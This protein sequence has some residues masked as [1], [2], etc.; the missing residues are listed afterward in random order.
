L[1]DST[2]RHNANAHRYTPDQL[3]WVGDKNKDWCNF[4]GYSKLAHDPENPTGVFEY[5]EVDEEMNRQYYGFQAQNEAMVNWAC[6]LNDDDLTRYRYRLSDPAK[7][8]PLLDFG[9]SAKVT[10]PITNY[11]EKKFYGKAHTEVA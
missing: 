3:K 6:H 7:D 5:D 11:I 2:K 9:S 1:K 10:G 8:V 4:F